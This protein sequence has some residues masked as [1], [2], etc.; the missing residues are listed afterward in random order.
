MMLLGSE[1]DWELVL[2]WALVKEEN[3]YT[4]CICI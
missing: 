2:W 1:R 3:H 4:L